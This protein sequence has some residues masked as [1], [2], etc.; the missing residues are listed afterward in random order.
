VQFEVIGHAHRLAIATR[1]DFGFTV[2]PA[3]PDRADGV[4]HIFCRES[5]RRCGDC[6]SRHHRSIALAHAFALA[7]DLWAAFVVNGAADAASGQQVGVRRVDNGV[8][9]ILSEVSVEQPELVRITDHQ[10]Q[11][12]VLVA[13]QSDSDIGQELIL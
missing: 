8:S 13:R 1:Q 4:N 11:G 7:S 10:P 6:A 2:C 5:A 3:V 12:V 9:G